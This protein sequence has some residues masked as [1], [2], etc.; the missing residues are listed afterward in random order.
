MIKLK[1]G[2]GGV[3][4]MYPSMRPSVLEGT[5]LTWTFS[6]VATNRWVTFATWRK[7]SP[8]TGLVPSC[9]VRVL[10]WRSLVMSPLVKTTLPSVKPAKKHNI[11]YK[12]GRECFVNGSVCREH[13]LSLH[14][15][16]G[17]EVEVLMYA[18]ARHFGRF[19]AGNCGEDPS[20][21]RIST[22]SLVK[23]PDLHLRN[24]SV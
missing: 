14:L 15:T 13:T 20:A 21:E 23:V 5:R 16:N 1:E 17:H 12:P 11:H 6:R 9:R 19:V 7:A 22:V 2:S 10:L 24:D 8:V 4:R 3:E 18:E